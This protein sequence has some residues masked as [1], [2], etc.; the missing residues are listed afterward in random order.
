MAAKRID[1]VTELR[2]EHEI[3]DEQGYKKGQDIILE[4]AGL[5][6]HIYRSNVPL[7]EHFSSLAYSIISG[8]L[9]LYT[10]AIP[11]FDKQGVLQKI[12]FID[13][14]IGESLKET[15][16]LIESTLVV[17]QVVEINPCVVDPLIDSNMFQV[18]MRLTKSF[19]RYKYA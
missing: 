15:Q 16:A 4:C 9:T 1:C 8:L 10:S 17:P 3:N 14:K 6:F 12:D 13:E 2:L 11:C 18:I 19:S 5:I 7:T